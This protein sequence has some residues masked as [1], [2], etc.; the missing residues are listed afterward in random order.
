MQLLSWIEITHRHGCSL[1]NMLHVFRTTFPK[2]H[3]WMPASVN[4]YFALKMCL[5]FNSQLTNWVLPESCI[6]KTLATRDSS[7]VHKGDSLM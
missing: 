7:L 5:Q 3:F 6:S 4:F 2:E 1:V